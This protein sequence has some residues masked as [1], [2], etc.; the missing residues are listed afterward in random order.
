MVEQN[1]GMKVHKE[2]GCKIESFSDNL[3]KDKEVF[4]NA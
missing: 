2:C 3:F 1:I 4:L